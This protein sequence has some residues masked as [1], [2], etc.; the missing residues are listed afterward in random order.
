M[1]NI[2]DKARNS[3]QTRLRVEKGSNQKLPESCLNAHEPN[4]RGSR[5]T[6]VRQHMLQKNNNAKRLN[7]SQHI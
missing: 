4:G 6:K 3:C 5:W 2:Q 7:I 1:G